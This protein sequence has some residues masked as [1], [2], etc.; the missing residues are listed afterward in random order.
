MSFKYIFS[1]E[2]ETNI[3]KIA[4]RDKV[5][6]FAIRKKVSQIVSLDE[7]A[8]QHFK[9]LRGDWKNY[10][11]VHVGSFVLM[12]KVEGNLTVFDRLLHHDEAYRS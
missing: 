6:A 11:R 1:D 3:R 10:K 8:I 5:L 7:T 12:F 9:N 4:R 2:L